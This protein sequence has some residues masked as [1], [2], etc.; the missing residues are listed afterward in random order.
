MRNPV[1]LLIASLM[2]PLMGC[3]GDNYS[4]HYPTYPYGGEYDG[5]YGDGSYG[6]EYDGG[7]GYDID[8]GR[9]V[10]GEWEGFMTE[11]YRSDHR[12]LCKRKL[13]MR[14]QRAGT[15]YDYWGSYS[16]VNIDVLL[17]GRPVASSTTEVGSGGRIGFN[18]GKNDFSMSGRF[19]GGSADGTMSL[20]WEE[21]VKNPYTGEP[22]LRHVHI[23]GDFSMGR[24]H[25]AHWAAA[26]A[27]FDTYGEG[28]WD[29]PDEVWEAATLEG[30]AHL[31]VIEETL[32]R[33]PAQ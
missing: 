1:A 15:G 23:A 18:A 21:K 27:L 24:V 3:F 4:R 31:A 19:S 26:W 10:E 7:G 8:W 25:G 12:P 16:L 28:I 30:L 20:T 13:A 9:E 5:G 29:L 32:P 2:L 14:I 33:V 17:D 6:G 11:N 22:E